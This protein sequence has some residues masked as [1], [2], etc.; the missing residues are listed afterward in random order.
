M[1]DFL[2]RAP[3]LAERLSDELDGDLQERMANADWNQVVR[4]SAKDGLINLSYESVQEDNIFESE[5][6]S[7]R[8]SPNAVVRPFL[9]ESQKQLE[10]AIGQEAIDFLFSEGILP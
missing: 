4:I 9:N 7:P 1:S 5:Y 8:L 10:T 3:R 2:N 6:G